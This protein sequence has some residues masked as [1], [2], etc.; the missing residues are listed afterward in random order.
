[1]KDSTRSALMAVSLVGGISAYQHAMALADG[2]GLC[3]PAE[4]QNFE[5]V[6]LG[7]NVIEFI[8]TQAVTNGG[9]TYNYKYTGTTN[10]QLNVAIPTRTAKIITPAVNAQC[11]QYLTGGAGDPTTGFGKNQ[12]TLAICRIAFN[13]NTA[14]VPF[15]ITVDPSAVDRKNPLDWQLKQGHALYA[16]SL[17][18]PFTPQAEITESDVTLTTPTGNTVHYSNLGGNIQIIPSG[19]TSPSARVLPTG[20]LKICTVNANPPN[21]PNVPFTSADFKN[22]W[23]CET[24][25]F[26]TDQ[27][28]IKT[29]GSDP[30]RSIGGSMI[31]Y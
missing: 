19:T 17:V 27:C 3:S 25:T 28:D 15:S 6:N 31:C 13:L 10:N 30:C 8:G 23:S 29:K 22:N 9:T 21:D 24:V 16:G 4:T 5:C 2:N 1:M 14:T 26:V 12:L 18:G 20:G 7:A 11:S